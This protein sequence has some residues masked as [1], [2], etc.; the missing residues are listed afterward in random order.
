[1]KAFAVPGAYVTTYAPDASQEPRAAELVR[2]YQ[3]IFGDFEQYGA[4]AYVAM[5]V[6]LQ[7]ALDVC[8]EQ[9]EVTRAAMVRQLPR[10]RLETSI[11]GTPIAFT[12]EH[13][14][15]GA[16]TNVYQVGPRGFELVG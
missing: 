15:E 8:R 6:V 2:L 5:Q 13:E 12:P 16:T 10:T 11:L 14:L 7:A 3:T 9:G 1:M 4:P